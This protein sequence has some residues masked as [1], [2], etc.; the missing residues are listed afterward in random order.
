M[1]TK[2]LIA[3][4]GLQPRL[5]GGVKFNLQASKIMEGSNVCEGGNCPEHDFGTHAVGT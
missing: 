3:S 1:A 2:L 5:D 4:E